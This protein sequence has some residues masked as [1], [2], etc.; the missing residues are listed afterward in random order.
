M[1]EGR[2]RRQLCL[3]AEASSLLATLG[4]PIVWEALMDR[5]DARIPR[6]CLTEAILRPVWRAGRR[7]LVWRGLQRRSHFPPLQIGV[8]G[9]CESPRIPWACGVSAGFGSPSVTHYP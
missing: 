2:G 4:V 3:R 1:E 6:V 8:L 7:P 5:D 9:F